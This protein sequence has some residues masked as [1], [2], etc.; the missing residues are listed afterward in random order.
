MQI[1]MSEMTLYSRS[2]SD[3]DEFHDALEHLEEEGEEVYHVAVAEAATIA[4]DDEGKVDKELIE[5]DSESSVIHSHSSGAE[6]SLRVYHSATDEKASESPPQPT[7]ERDE[8]PT[9]ENLQSEHSVTSSLYR[10]GSGEEGISSE[11]EVDD[12]LLRMKSLFDALSGSGSEELENA[13]FT[14]TQCHWSNPL[15]NDDAVIDSIEVQDSDERDMI[16]EVMNDKEHNILEIEREGINDVETKSIF[17]TATNNSIDGEGAEKILINKDFINDAKITFANES[18]KN[19]NGEHLENSTTKSKEDE[20]EGQ[21]SVNEATVDKEEKQSINRKESTSEEETEEGIMKTTISTST[22]SSFD[23]PT[24]SIA[25]ETTEQFSEESQEPAEKSNDGLGETLA[26]K[27]EI[28]VQEQ[29]VVDGDYTTPKKIDCDELCDMGS[30]LEALF[31]FCQGNRSGLGIDTTDKGIELPLRTTSF[32]DADPKAPAPLSPVEDVHCD[33]ESD[34]SEDSSIDSIS[35]FRVMN[36][37]DN[38][39]AGKN[40]IDGKE[41]NDSLDLLPDRITLEHKRSLSTRSNELDQVASYSFDESLSTL[42]TVSTPGSPTSN[43]RRKANDLKQKI[44]RGVAGLSAKKGNRK[45]TVSS[46]G[47]PSNAVYV[48]SSKTRSVQTCLQ[49]SP[50]EDSPILSKTDSSFNPMLLVKTIQAHEGPAWCAAFSDDGSFLAT[51]GEDGNVAIWAVSPKSKKLHPKGVSTRVQEKQ[52]EERKNEAEPFSF[53]GLGPEMATN[54]EIVSSEP[55]QRYRDHTADVIDLSWSECLILRTSRLVV[56]NPSL[57]KYCS[58]YK[59]HTNFLLTASVDKSVRLYHFSKSKCL[60]L[61]KHANLVASVDFHPLDDRY[62]ISG[63]LDKK[64]RMW[65]ITD[66][67]VKEWAQV[68]LSR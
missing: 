57:I 4:T 44:K 35:R 39:D 28:S 59:G 41:S 42:S 50:S 43:A 30:P 68:S 12:D 29:I 20:Q 47:L 9:D 15:S 46:E 8:V 25:D 18:E 32:M 36:I 17:D 54:V 1:S 63:G 21:H 40:D 2:D 58:K 10:M 67:R 14:T 16:E 45:R 62:F 33:Y 37:D 24:K 64:L 5:E 56:N 53:I 27:P 6:Q 65:N 55:I 11:I 66:G 34:S 49:S 38:Y 3:A 7:R 52:N 22:E 51:G 23:T 26:M 61:F 13:E 48:R 19:T 60:H 31:L